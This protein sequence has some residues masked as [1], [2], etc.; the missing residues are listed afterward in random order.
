[1]LPAVL[2]DLDPA[3]ALHRADDALLVARARDG[4]RRAFGV[5]LMRHESTLRRYITRLTHQPADTDDVLQET[6]LKAWQHLDALA[7]PAKVRAWMIQIASREALR[8]VTARRQEHE[9]SEDD[10]VVDGPDRGEHLDTRRRLQAALDALPEQQE[11]CWVL[12][13]LGGYS[14]RE[15]AEQLDL[16]ES[17]VRGALVA[18]RKSILTAMEGSA[19]S[20]P[21]F[22]LGFEPE[23]LDGHSI[24]ELTDYLE[25]GRT[26]ADPS[27]E[28]SPACRNALRALERLRDLARRL[29]R[30]P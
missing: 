8:F 22:V 13:E 16:P 18:A 28:G 30:R 14:Y 21:V 12:R 7:E 2:P 10:A 15:I 20:D 17:T 27:I 3:S 23:D 9:L 24:D 6:A 11:R 1:M 25:R 26:P 5:L 19:M 4:D 29:P